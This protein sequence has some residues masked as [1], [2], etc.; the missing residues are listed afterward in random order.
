MP[1]KPKKRSNKSD[2][3]GTIGG[4]HGEAKSKVDLKQAFVAMQIRAM[5]R[6]AEPITLEYQI[7][8]VAGVKALNHALVQLTLDRKVDG[9]TLGAINGTLANQIRM[10]IG[11][12]TV[13]QEVKVSMD[14]KRVVTLEELTDVLG[15]LPLDTQDLVIN[16][17]KQ[18]RIG[19]PPGSQAQPIEVR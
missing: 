1:K 18:R 8:D 2:P 3:Q 14:A 19:I 9:R 6:A 13:T 17:L 16:A 5:Q 11:P 4:P 12:V 7:N 15:S 10:L